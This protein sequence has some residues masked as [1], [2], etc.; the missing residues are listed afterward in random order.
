MGGGISDG[1]VVV[2]GRQ[3]VPGVAKTRLGEGIGDRRAADV[4]E[5][6]LRHTLNE[7]IASELPVILELA[8]LPLEGWETPHGLQWALQSAGD[9]GTRMRT[10]F[11]RCFDAGYE[12]VVLVGSDIPG[13]SRAHLR[14]SIQLL[15]NVPVVLGPARD[16]G[17]YLVGQRAPGADL[18]TGITWSVPDTLALTRLRLLDLSLGYGEVETLS[19][20]DVPADL[21]QAVASRSLSADLRAALRRAALME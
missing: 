14:R 11:G 17:Y 20:V 5:V 1:C 21:E 12:R 15:D 8:E 3:P 6:M 2:F 13:L 9:L 16:G 19:D 7:A 4:Y 10:A 18:F